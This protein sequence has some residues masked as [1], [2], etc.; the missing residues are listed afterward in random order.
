MLAG[1]CVAFA[2]PEF[3]R[4]LLKGHVLLIACPKLDDFEAHLEKLTDILHCARPKG[5]TIVHMEVPCCAGLVLMAKQ[6]LAASGINIPLKE[7]TVGTR[8]AIL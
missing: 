5:I 4:N 6:A 1:D 7:I 2:H 8:G 3:H